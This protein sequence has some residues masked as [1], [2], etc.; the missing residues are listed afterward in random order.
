MCGTVRAGH[1]GWSDEATRGPYPFLF[2]WKAP[3]IA[4]LH[5]QLPKD[6]ALRCG[7]EIIWVVCMAEPR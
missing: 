3:S 4:F 7:I 6:I 2:P 5:Q 1:D